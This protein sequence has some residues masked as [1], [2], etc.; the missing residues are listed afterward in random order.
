[1]KAVIR[2]QQQEIAL[3]SG[4]SGSVPPQERQQL[5]DALQQCQIASDMQEDEDE[6]HYQSDQ[7]NNAAGDAAAEPDPTDSLF[8][9]ADR[10]THAVP[11]GYNP[12]SIEITFRGSAGAPIDASGQSTTPKAP[13]R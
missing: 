8:A 11:A 3:Q 4:S 6:E 10:P 1:M 9:S 7:E 5:V 12:S 13:R 2:T